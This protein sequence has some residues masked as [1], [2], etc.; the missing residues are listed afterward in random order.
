MVCHKMLILRN[1]IQVTSCQPSPHTIV[2]H[3]STALIS[4]TPFL[5][6]PFPPHMS[7]SPLPFLV[8]SLHTPPHPTI[9]H[10]L[11]STSPSTPL[12][13]QENTEEKEAHNLMLHFSLSWSNGPPHHRLI[14]ELDTALS[15]KKLREGVCALQLEAVT[16]TCFIV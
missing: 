7:R 2:L 11:P 15:L 4:S 9:L 12:S 10:F 6:I 13:L 8:L 14:T 3:S 5:P 1:R 16:V